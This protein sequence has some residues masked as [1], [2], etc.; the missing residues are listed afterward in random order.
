MVTSEPNLKKFHRSKREKTSIYL[1]RWCHKNQKNT[2]GTRVVSHLSTRSYDAMYRVREG[3]S[4]LEPFYRLF[5]ELFLPYFF[6]PRLNHMFEQSLELLLR[7]PKRLNALQVLEWFSF[8]LK[9]RPNDR[10]MPTQHVATLLGATCCVRLATVLQC[11]ATCWV[12][13]AEV[14]NWSHLSQQHP[15]G[16]NTVAKHPQNVAPNDVAIRCVGMLRSIGRGFR[17]N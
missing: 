13:L 1:L 10:N 15:T 14:W 11:V 4:K 7:I 16:R 9:P 6:G 12:L 3:K 5:R 2:R 8:L 17:P